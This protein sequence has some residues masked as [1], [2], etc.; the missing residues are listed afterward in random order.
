M[1]VK[2]F[3]KKI[4][5]ESSEIGF[6]ASSLAFSTLL[7]LVPFLVVTLAVFQNFG[8][9]ESIYP[10]VEGLIFESMKDATGVTITRYIR[11]TI[12]NVQF[13]TLGI[14]GILLL[15][16]SSLNLLKNIDVAFHR[17][18]HIKMKK[19]FL[20]RTGLYWIL[21]IATPFVLL[22][23]SSIRNINLSQFVSH[24]SEKQFLMFIYGTFVLWVLYV[25]IPEIKVSIISAAISASLAGA[26]ISFVQKSF[27]WAALKLFKQNKIYGSLATFPIFLI[28][29]W[30]IW[31][32]ILSGVSLCA[33]LQQKIFKRP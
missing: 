33:F 8:I 10:K 21:L 5:Q 20:K 1:I 3:F 27:L 11:E 29:L 23:L 2:F 19:P 18:W 26:S 31:Y 13:K 28:W 6:S 25:Y 24:A 32:I 16:L 7:S 12:S 30:V 4:Y 17:I 15:L 22:G 14:T 9:F